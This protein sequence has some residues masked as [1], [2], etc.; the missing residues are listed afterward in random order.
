MVA[1]DCGNVA[2]RVMLASGERGMIG[3][4]LSLPVPRGGIEELESPCLGE[5]ARAP[6]PGLAS[7]LRAFG[8]PD[9]RAQLGSRRVKSDDR[10][11]AALI[12]SARRGL[13]R[14]PGPEAVE[15]MLAR[16]R[17]GGEAPYRIMI[18]AR[19]CSRGIEPPHR[20]L[21][22]RSSARGGRP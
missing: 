19:P 13:G 9:R 14:T 7:T 15:A 16:C 22:L 21:G 20:S 4:P 18:A 8:G 2:S 6:L 5:G 10:G 1:I 12:A 11:C 3:K 17:G